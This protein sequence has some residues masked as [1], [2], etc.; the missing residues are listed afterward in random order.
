MLTSLLLL[1][2][3]RV[4]LSKPSVSDEMSR[5]TTSIK[6]MEEVLNLDHETSWS[7]VGTI[8]SVNV[9]LKDWFNVSC[10]TCSKKVQPNKDRYWCDHYRKVGFNGTLRYR[11]AVILTDGTSCIKV[12][13]WN[14]EAKAIVE[15]SANTY[16]GSLYPKAFDAIIERK[17][18]FK[19]SVTSRNIRSIGQAYNVVKLSDDESLIESPTSVNIRYV[20]VVQGR[21]YSFSTTLGGGSHE[22]DQSF[23]TTLGG[24]CQLE[25][26]S[27]ANG[28][29]FTSPSKDYPTESKYENVHASPTKLVVGEVVENAAMVGI[30][31]LDGQG[32]SN[33]S[34]KRNVGKR[35]LE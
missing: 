32:S 5:G 11:L 2:S 10:N 25:T 1:V 26:K 18:L 16:L 30:C 34:F 8:V 7:I 19:L 27:K 12:A 3:K 23:S 28:L 33:K 22:G 24:S 31:T 14:S 29:G 15:K 9:G 17:Y 21:V 4:C 35:K 20:S 6:L 13:L